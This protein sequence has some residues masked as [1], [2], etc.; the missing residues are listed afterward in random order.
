MVEREGSVVIFLHKPLHLE[1]PRGGVQERRD[2]GAKDPKRESTAKLSVI[3]DCSCSGRRKLPA[4]VTRQKEEDGYRKFNQ[5][6]RK[7]D[8][9]IGGAV[10]LFAVRTEVAGWRRN[11]RPRTGRLWNVFYSRFAFPCLGWT[12]GR[13]ASGRAG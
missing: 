8:N 13:L 1:V 10:N 3:N 4:K 7:E 2:V 5:Y 9:T 12:L 6:I 11:P